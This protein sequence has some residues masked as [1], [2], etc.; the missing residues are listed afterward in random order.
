MQ[1]ESTEIVFNGVSGV[2]AALKPDNNISIAG[3]IINHTAFAFIS[4]V[5]PDD[6]A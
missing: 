2:V 5:D 1:F 6:D 3:E 4:P